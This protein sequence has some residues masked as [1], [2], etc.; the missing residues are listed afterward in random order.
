MKQLILALVSWA[1]NSLSI[2]ESA[3]SGLRSNFTEHK[4]GCKNFNLGKYLLN[5]GIPG[6][7]SNSQML[8]CSVIITIASLWRR[9]QTDTTRVSQL[10]YQ[11]FH[12]YPQT[13]HFTHG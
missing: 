2:S 8:T 7:V 11:F 9:S 1:S 12:L 3:V 13:K 6:L 10:F 5:F 4:A